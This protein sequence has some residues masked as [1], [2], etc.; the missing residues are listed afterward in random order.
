[1][2]LLFSDYPPEEQARARVPGS[3]ALDPKTLATRGRELRLQVLGEQPS[4]RDASSEAHAAHGSIQDTHYFGVLWSNPELSLKHRCLVLLGVIC[5]SCRMDDAEMWFGAA[6]RLGWTQEE[7]EEVLLSAG[8][9][10]GEL[11]YAR[12]RRALLSTLQR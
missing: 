4:S 3:V 12:G 9:Y 2:R 6:L 10:C 5:G 7:L 11:T 1:M 8:I